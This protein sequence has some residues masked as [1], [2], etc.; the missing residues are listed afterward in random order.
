MIC[1]HL[2]FV[3]SYISISLMSSYLIFG[4]E[5]E[6]RAKTLQCMVHV[7]L[8]KAWFTYYVQVRFRVSPYGGAH[9]I[10]NTNGPHT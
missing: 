3:Q 7:R 5:V 9:L 4:K 2:L 10:I 8:C 1:P 6:K